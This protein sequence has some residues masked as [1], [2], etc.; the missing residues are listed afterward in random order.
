M[1]QPC[2]SH[3]AVVITAKDENVG[4]GD[5]LVTSIPGLGGSRVVGGFGGDMI[6]RKSYQGYGWSFGYLYFDVSG[7]TEEVDQAILTM[8]IMGAAGSGGNT[9]TAASFEIYNLTSSFHDTDGTDDG[10]FGDYDTLPGGAAHSIGGAAPNY[11]EIY[12]VPDKATAWYESQ[13]GTTTVPVQSA[14]TF[15]FS[16]N[17]V[18]NFG[19]AD[20]TSMV[21]DW[22]SGRVE[23]KGMGLLLVSPN[24]FRIGIEGGNN[25]QRTNPTLTLTQVPE[26]ASTLLV[27]LAGLAGLGIRRRSHKA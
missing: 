17:D 3:A 21:N 9:A 8:E 16:G 2:V 14:A 22:I 7:Q 11:W 4:T 24:V 13:F 23:N 1:I 5:Y 25:A 15:T 27:A 12:G 26:P 20:I 6:V 19:T 10:D 18:G